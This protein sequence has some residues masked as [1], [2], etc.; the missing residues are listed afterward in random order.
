MCF[1]C[2]DREGSCT[3]FK[4]VKITDKVLQRYSPELKEAWDTFVYGFQILEAINEHDG[5]IDRKSIPDK[6]L[7]AMALILSERIPGYKYKTGKSS[8]FMRCA[9]SKMTVE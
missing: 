6:V 1:D 9:L 2:C 7:E 4:G 8:C 5:L 3:E